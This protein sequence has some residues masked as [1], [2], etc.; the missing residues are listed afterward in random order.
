[1]LLPKSYLLRRD[2]LSALVLTPTQRRSSA[3]RKLQVPRRLRDWV[4]KV[5]VCQCRPRDDGQLR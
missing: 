1:M 2:Y 3:S 4:G 5:R